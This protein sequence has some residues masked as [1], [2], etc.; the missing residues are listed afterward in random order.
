MPLGCVSWISVSQRVPNGGP[1]I[2]GPQVI[3]ALSSQRSVPAFGTEAIPPKADES[4]LQM[5]SI[6]VFALILRVLLWLFAGRLPRLDSPDPG[7][8]KTGGDG[9]GK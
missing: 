3:P 4:A 9:D 2:D 5:Q 6:P 7:P 1:D 8:K